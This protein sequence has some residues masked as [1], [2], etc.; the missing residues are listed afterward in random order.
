[1]GL[2]AWMPWE[3]PW[4]YPIHTILLVHSSVDSVRLTSMDLG[5]CADAWKGGLRFTVCAISMQWDLRGEWGCLPLHK[6]FLYTNTNR[7]CQCLHAGEQDM[8]QGY[9]SLIGIPRVVLLEKRAEEI[10]GMKR[11]AD[12]FDTVVK[13]VSSQWYFVQRIVRRGCHRRLALIRWRCHW[14]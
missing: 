11:V 13:T 1:M 12:D 14:L 2:V 9:L 7:Q 10:G 4:L 8:P 3:H 5:G 6:R